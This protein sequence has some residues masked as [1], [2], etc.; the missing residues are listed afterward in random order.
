MAISIAALWTGNIYGTNT[1]KLFLRLE[2]DDASLQAAVHLNDDNRGIIVIEAVGSFKGQS[3]SLS[4]DFPG[5]PQ[6][7]IDIIAKLNPDGNFRGGWTTNF[8]AAGTLA[9]FPDDV[10]SEESPQNRGPAQLY[11]ARHVLGP[12]VI[13]RRELDAIA[14]EMQSAFKRSKLV[15]TVYTDTE[16]IFYLDNLAEKHFSAHRASIVKLHVQE[17]DRDGL[18][19]LISLELGPS[20]NMAMTQ[21]TDE[22]WVIGYLEKLKNLTN[23][24]T[25]GLFYKLRS[26]GVGFNQ[27]AILCVVVFLPSLNG[28]LERSILMVGVIV[29]A[30]AVKRGQDRIFQNAVIY[31][32][33]RS[34][35]LVER[36]GPPVVSLGVAVLGGALAT[37][38]AVW[39]QKWFG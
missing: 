32:G 34:P 1:G 29:I 25:R 24:F 30:F 15:V 23:P 10:F 35:S 14:R 2:G 18:N 3:L 31:L 16:Q 6:Q 20:Y 8:G 13:D 28:L 9:L 7:S 38:L 12:V 33:E 5:E 26:I 39:L 27:I 4:G 11:T 21:G 17:P 37:L 22:T 36:A 19:R